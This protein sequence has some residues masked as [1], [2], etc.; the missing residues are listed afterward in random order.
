ML[1]L[2]FRD[3]NIL[4]LTLFFMYTLLSFHPIQVLN[5]L[6][7]IGNDV[8]FKESIDYHGSRSSMENEM[9]SILKN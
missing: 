7:T 8:S 9:G 2:L 4:L 5:L 1:I 3:P 6:D